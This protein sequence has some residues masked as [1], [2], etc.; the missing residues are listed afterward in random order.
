MSGTG[1]SRKTESI[2]CLLRNGR[3][4]GSKRRF[5]FEVRKITVIMVVNALKTMELFALNVWIMYEL[6]F[7]KPVSKKLEDIRISDNMD[8]NCTLL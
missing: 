8:L 3:V 6:H 7:N 1:T 4:G 5:L 2:L